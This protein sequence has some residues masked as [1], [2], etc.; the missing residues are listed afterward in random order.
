VE[1]LKV[2]SK[3]KYKVIE[4]SKTKHNNLEFYVTIERT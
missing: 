1:D 3:I 4:Y 2:Y